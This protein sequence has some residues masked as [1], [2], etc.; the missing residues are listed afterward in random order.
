LDEDA[1]WRVGVAIGALPKIGPELL[2][3]QP[4]VHRNAEERAGHVRFA[5]QFSREAVGFILV[6]ARKDEGVRIELRP[7]P[8]DELREDGSQGHL[9]FNLWSAHVFK[10][11]FPSAA[12]AIKPMAEASMFF[13]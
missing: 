9:A 1:H 13:G 6:G 2:V 7:E 11:P 10:E 3:H 8:T 12:Q 4:A 5:G